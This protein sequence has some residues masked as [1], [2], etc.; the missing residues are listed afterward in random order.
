[1]DAT[2]IVRGRIVG[3]EALSSGV[4]TGPVSLGQTPGEIRSA[5]KRYVARVRPK[6]CCGDTGSWRLRTMALPSSDAAT[7]RGNPTSASPA[8]SASP[9]RP[10][11][12]VG[13]RRL[14]VGIRGRCA[15]SRLGLCENREGRRRLP[16]QD[17]ATSAEMAAASRVGRRECAGRTGGDTE[18]SARGSVDLT[19]ADSN[20]LKCGASR[21]RIPVHPSVQLSH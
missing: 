9:W 21:E 16:W 8:S 7:S 19:A 10:C 5:G 15:G 12:R 17:Y 2:T 6:H 18:T 1:M 20:S 11:R 13:A 14:V 3:E 4:S